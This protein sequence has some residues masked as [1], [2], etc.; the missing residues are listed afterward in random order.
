MRPSRPSRSACA[1]RSPGPS[2]SRSCSA[3]SSSPASSSPSTSP[4]AA[5]S[6][7][8]AASRADLVRGV[9]TNPELKLLERLE[10]LGP[11]RPYLFGGDLRSPRAGASP[12]QALLAD[13][14]AEE[15]RTALAE[16]VV[17]VLQSK[18]GELPSAI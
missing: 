15:P 10:K 14:T 17:K 9:L 12:A 3:C 6:G 18:E 8:S 16:G 11:V 1:A 4:S 7:R 13:F 5:P 2:S